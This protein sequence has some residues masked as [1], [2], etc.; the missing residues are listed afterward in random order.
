MDAS[1][2]ILNFAILAVVLSADLGRRQIGPMRLLRPVIAAAVIIPS[3]LAGK[4]QWLGFS[5]RWAVRAPV[6][7]PAIGAGGRAHGR[8]ILADRTAPGALGRDR[9]DF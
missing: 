8:A 1:V 4:A 2:W 9:H 3:G 5:W 6:T 7:G